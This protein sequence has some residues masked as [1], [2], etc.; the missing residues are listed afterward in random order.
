MIVCSANCFLQ[1]ALM[2]CS[3]KVF[4]TTVNQWIRRIYLTYSACCSNLH[5][6]PST[7]SSRLIK[8]ERMKQLVVITP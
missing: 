8:T 5:G 1:H 6:T 3:Q 4:I 2:I 7:Q